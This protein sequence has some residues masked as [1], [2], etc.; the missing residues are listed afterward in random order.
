MKIGQLF[1]QSMAREVQEGLSNSTS[2]FLIT[3]RNVS[4]VQMNSLRKDLRKVGAQMYVTRNTIIRHAFKDREGSELVNKLEGT[5]ALVWS[6]ADSARISKV[7]VKFMEDFKGVSVQGGLLSG[8]ILDK[9]D[10]K[11]ISELPSREQLLATLLRIMISPLARFN[12]LLN[13]K[14]RD[15]LSIMKQLSEKKGGK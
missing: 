1:R 7:L 9:V 11:R 4:G 3:Y 5:T 10:I 12:G 2:I 6:N 15:L 8:K 14:I 13:S